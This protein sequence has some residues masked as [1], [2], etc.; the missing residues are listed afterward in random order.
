[1]VTE[2][3]IKALKCFLKLNTHLNEVVVCSYWNNDK[4]WKVTGILKGINNF[5]SIKIDNQVLRFIGNSSVIRSII[6]ISN[7]EVLFSNPYVINSCNKDDINKVTEEVFG[8]LMQIDSLTSYDYQRYK[9][10]KDSFLF[11]KNDLLEEWVNQVNSLLNSDKNYLLSFILVYL[12]RISLGESLESI[13]EIVKKLELHEKDKD[14]IKEV[15]YKYSYTKQE[16]SL[17]K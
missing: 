17:R 5:S 8:R 12:K 2:V 4:I 7:G 13:F 6:L 14:I 15:L 3:E 16:L 10:L 11:I 9:L 1:M